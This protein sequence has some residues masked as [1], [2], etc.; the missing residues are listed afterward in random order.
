MILKKIS[1][2]V[3]IF[4]LNTIKSTTSF[5]LDSMMSLGS[6]DCSFLNNIFVNVHDISQ[7][8]SCKDPKFLIYKTILFI[9]SLV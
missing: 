3:A 2:N 8:A 5:T 9:F 6:L 7:S 1:K 4:T